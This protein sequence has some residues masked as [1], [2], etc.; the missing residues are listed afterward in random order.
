MTAT[1]KKADYKVADISLAKWG[2][3]EIRMAEHEMPGLMAVRKEYADA[4]PLAGAK[5]HRNGPVSVAQEVDIAGLLPQEE[6]SGE[7]FPLLRL[8]HK[9]VQHASWPADTRE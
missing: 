2:R 7:L 6:V 5:I 8:L 3:E 1:E 4:K 9:G